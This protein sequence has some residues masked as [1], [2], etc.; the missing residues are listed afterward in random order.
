MAGMISHCGLRCDEC[1]AYKATR[2]DDDAMRIQVAEKWSIQYRS[3]IKPEDIDCEGCLS[4]GD[5]V[6]SHCH[7]CEIRKCGMERGVPNCAHCQ[8]YV[9][10]KLDSFLQK[11]PGNRKLL[12]GI[13]KEISAGS[14]R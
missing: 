7:V 4:G 5:K 6:F 9:C 12:E 1:A 10:S 8:D 2:A 3:D 11:V 14:G 13:R